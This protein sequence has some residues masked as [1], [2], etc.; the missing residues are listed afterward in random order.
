MKNKLA[1]SENVTNFVC[2]FT[3]DL[4]LK[5]RWKEYPWCFVLNHPN[6]S[7]FGRVIK[8]FSPPPHLGRV[9]P[10]QHW[11]RGFLEHTQIDLRSLI[12]VQN[13]ALK[14]MNVFKHINKIKNFTEHTQ[15]KSW[16]SV[17]GKSNS[18]RLMYRALGLFCMY[19]HVIR[20]YLYVCICI[21]SV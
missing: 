3:L 6:H 11:V 16:S 17:G 18:D 12:A 13:H 14:Q 10:R 1:Y 2:L 21:T 15:I 9:L 8:F 7:K 19:V 20:I 4:Y 5:P